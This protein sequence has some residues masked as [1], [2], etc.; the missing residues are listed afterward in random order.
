MFE[1]LNGRIR[2]EFS[3]L[4][5]V[6]LFICFIFSSAVYSFEGNEKE[7]YRRKM[8]KNNY[9][10]YMPVTQVA[11][12]N[13][14]EIGSFLINS[15]STGCARI[16]D[17]SIKR[18]MDLSLQNT[19]NYFQQKSFSQRLNIN[20][21]NQYNSETK[22]WKKT[23]TVT[24]ELTSSFLLSNTIMYASFSVLDV[25]NYEGK[26]PYLFS[27]LI[28]EPLG[29]TCGTLGIGKLCHENGSTKGTVIGSLVGSAV[30][31]WGFCIFHRK[32][33]R[34]EYDEGLVVSF[35][36][37]SFAPSLGSVIGYNMKF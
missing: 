29:A 32:L 28:G 23:L 19:E 36:I 4:A 20:N 3:K 34:E 16:M 27:Y 7:T 8:F 12:T 5:F 9:P 13:Q 25:Y 26:Y 31:Y 10:Q 30:G 1:F 33:A 22:G 2:R 21:E 37:L 6:L 11:F 15:T 17:M 14:K 24:G 18:N 35:I